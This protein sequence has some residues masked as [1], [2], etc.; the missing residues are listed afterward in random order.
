MYLH[1]IKKRITPVRDGNIPTYCQMFLTVSAI[2]KRITPVRD[3]HGEQIMI[4]LLAMIVTVI[5]V[6]ID[7]NRM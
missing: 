3:E 1:P 2:K 6:I 5:I 7:I 4:K